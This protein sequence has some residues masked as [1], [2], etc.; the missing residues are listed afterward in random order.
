MEPRQHAGTGD[1]RVIQQ[2]ASLS[3]PRGWHPGGLGWALARGQLAERVVLFE[4][5]GRTVAWVALGMDDPDYHLVQV[6]PDHPDL[7]REVINWLLENVDARRAK[8]EVTDLDRPAVAALAQAG[9]FPSA[10]AQVLGMRRTARHDSQALPAGYTV[11]SVRPDELEARVEVHRSAW[12][13]ED[14]PY[15]P[16]RQPRVEPGATSSFTKHSYQAVRDTWLYQPGLDLVALDLDGEMVG[17]CIAWYDPVNRVAEIEPM[18]VIAPHRG[19]GLAPAICR[20]VARRVADLGG[21]QLFINTGPRLE[22]PAPGR[23]YAA[24]GFETFVRAT[25]YSRPRIPAP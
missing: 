12:R 9:L 1:T 7:T 25:T 6:H 8:V 11:R 15:E 2:L 4:E 24:A 20:E 21:R 3:W 23:T 5:T 19:R 10:E 13:P 14:L 16:G 18:G 17:C 22:Y